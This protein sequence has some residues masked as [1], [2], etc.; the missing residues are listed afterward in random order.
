[1][2]KPLFASL[3]LGFL[4][5]LP[6]AMSGCATT[7]I[8]TVGQEANDHYSFWNGDVYEPFD[9]DHYYFIMNNMVHRHHHGIDAVIDYYPEGCRI[10]HGRV[11]INSSYFRHR[12]YQIL[13]RQRNPG[14]GGGSTGSRRRFRAPHI[15]QPPDRHIAPSVKHPASRKPAASPPARQTPQ[16]Q[17]PTQR[18]AQRQIVTQ[19]RI[20]PPRNAASPRTAP[21]QAP[22]RPHDSQ[23]PIL[24]KR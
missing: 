15:M 1:M 9:P 5:A 17:A 19:P 23:R 8:L 22:A 6:A 4:L 24:K 7:G 12:H 20:A 2:K 11:D 10:F 18:P 13:N 14:H 16:T 21:R 3:I